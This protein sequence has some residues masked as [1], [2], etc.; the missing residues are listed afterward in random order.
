MRG[1]VYGGINGM[2]MVVYGPGPN[3]CSHEHAK[4]FFSCNPSEVP[5]KQY[6]RP[7]TVWRRQMDNAVKHRDFEKAIIM[8]DLLKEVA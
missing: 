5:R 6:A 2:W 4:A 3:D 7:E 8:R 1:R